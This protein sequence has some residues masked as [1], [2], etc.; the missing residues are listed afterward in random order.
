VGAVGG[1][2]GYRPSNINWDKTK[3]VFYTRSFKAYRMFRSVVAKKFGHD[4]SIELQRLKSVTLSES[5]E[6][7]T[8]GGAT[9]YSDD[10]ICAFERTMTNE[11]TILKTKD[12]IDG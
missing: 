7:G 8:V 5:D 9:E 12:N 11:M 1:A 4:E 2:S 6:L 3:L 10:L